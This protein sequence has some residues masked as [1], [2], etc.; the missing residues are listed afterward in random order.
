MDK[1]DKNDKNMICFVIIGVVVGV[2]LCLILKKKEP[3]IS[4]GTVSQLFSKDGQDLYLNGPEINNYTNNDFNLEYDMP[5][6]I[7]DINRGYP[8]KNIEFKKYETSYLG[9][10]FIVPMPDL[11]GFG[12]IKMG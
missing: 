11:Y 2:V 12:S 4:G 3:F 10:E 5:T 9:D 8:T 6:R 1:M 7:F